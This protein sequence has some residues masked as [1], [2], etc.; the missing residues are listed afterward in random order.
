V[1][2]NTL[3]IVIHARSLPARGAWVEIRLFGLRSPL[4]LRRSPPGERGLKLDKEIDRQ[5]E[6]MVAPRPGSVGSLNG[7]A[8][9][10][11]RR[12]Y[13]L[14]VFD[15]GWDMRRRIVTKL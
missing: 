4:R 11:L 14:P 7:A 5:L 1:T 15:R 10:R 12:F 9:S 13:M 8:E 6:E 2:N 3:T